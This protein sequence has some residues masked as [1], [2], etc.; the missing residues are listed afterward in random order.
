M[1]FRLGFLLFG[2]FFLILFFVAS[3]IQ[4]KNRWQDKFDLRNHF[5]Y[6][7]NYGIKFKDNIYG[8]ISLIAMSLSL[9]AY[10]ATFDMSWER[11]FFVPI[12]VC[13]A[14][15]ALIIPFIVFVPVSKIKSHIAVLMIQILTSICLPGT[16]GIAALK[17]YQTEGMSPVAMAILWCSIAVALGI[18]ILMFNP[19]LSLRMEPVTK[20]KENGEKEY[21]RPKYIQL[22]FTEWLLLFSVLISS[23]LLFILLIVCK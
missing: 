6:E 18:V 16:I 3:F 23:I 19:N 11:P 7:V 13:G 22:A 8:N 10:F 14:L 1:G 12:V 20:E 4:Y 5:P 2:I 21:L 15:A 9:C 17:I